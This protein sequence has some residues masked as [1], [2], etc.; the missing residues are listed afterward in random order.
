MMMG[1][2]MPSTEITPL[3]PYQDFS[4]S[5]TLTVTRVSAEELDL[6]FIMARKQDDPAELNIGAR[7][8]HPSMSLVVD[9]NGG[10]IPEL[11]KKILNN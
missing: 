11:T 2:I 1:I 9:G 8:I 4:S 5:G 6:P 3:I 7:T 10:E